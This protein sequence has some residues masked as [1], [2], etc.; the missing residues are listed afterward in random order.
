M[1]RE[2]V[3]AF[4]PVDAG[5]I[6]DVT[7]GG[8]GHSSALLDA[9]GHLRV[10]GLDRD[11]VAVDAARA[12]LAGFG[13]RAEVRRARS[14]HL[15]SIV[16]ELGVGPVVGVLAD[17]GVSSPQLDRA[18]R[19]FGYSQSGPLDMR[20][21]PDDPTTAADLVNQASLRELADLLRRFGDERHAD[22]IARA[23]VAS[24]PVE[25]THDLAVI[26]RD[27][28]PAAA[29]RTGGHPAKR[30]FQALRIA[31][32]DELAVLAATLPQATDVLAPRGR[33]V[34]L[35]YHSGEDRI[36]KQFMRDAET[37]GCTC[38]PGLPCGCGA[39]PQFVPVGR[40][41]QR[42]DSSEIDQ[43]RRASSARLR[44]AERI[45]VAA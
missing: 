39:V 10:L 26:V 2:V 5:W 28:I 35:A 19:G 43:N 15:A 20:M 32:N 24:R 12:A 38:P 33:L 17:L 34:V 18:D 16:D 22:R 40:R 45:E 44:V 23:I 29:R 11:P 31:V 7:V 14:D 6:V 27:A 8:A 36:V 21:S 1:V 25:T 9:H 3:D 4:A 42:P 30:T 37:G 13:D 41:A